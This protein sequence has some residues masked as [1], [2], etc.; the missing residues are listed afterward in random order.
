MTLSMAEYTQGSENTMLPVDGPWAGGSLVC[1]TIELKGLMGPLDEAPQP[2]QLTGRQQT[3]RTSLAA[4]SAVMAQ[5]YECALRT[6]QDAGNSGRLFLAAHSIREMTN[7]LPKV[8]DL[9]ILAGQG[10]LG[11]QVS[12]LEP[13]WNRAVNGVCHRDGRWSGNI[14]A[15]LER[16]LRSLHEF[17]QWWRDS[18]PKRRDVAVNF[19]RRLDP[20]GLPL[21]KAL[22]EERADRWLELQNYFVRTAHRSDTTDVDFQTNLEALEQV[23]MDSLYRQPSE[24]LSI[25]DAILKEARDA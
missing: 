12:A 8:L 11:D 14:D 10:R 6:L 7:G 5:L 1:Y 2:F 18:R 24:D 17:F 21:P 13:A 3:V 20:A 22:E 25:I 9:P 4:K 23:L 16:L 15:S 19:F